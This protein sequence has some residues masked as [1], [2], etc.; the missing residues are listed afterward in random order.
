MH[1]SL[2]PTSAIR[3]TLSGC[4]FLLPSSPPHATPSLHQ[5]IQRATHHRSSSRTHRAAG[6]QAAYPC[7]PP[8]PP[9]EVHIWWSFP[10]KV[11]WAAV[12][13]Q[14]ERLLPAKELEGVQSAGDLELRRERLLTRVL[15]R[16]VLSSYLQVGDT[17]TR[18]RAIIVLRSAEGV[19]WVWCGRGVPCGIVQG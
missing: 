2:P 15:S 17:G 18:R 19:W 1:C 12:T 7:A 11:D 13:P 9:R 10:A 16:T 4:P 8:L 6:H 14:Y 3:H 5:C